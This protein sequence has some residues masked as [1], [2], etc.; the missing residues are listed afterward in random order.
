MVQNQVKKFHGL[1]LFIGGA[2]SQEL[3]QHVEAMQGRG[4]GADTVAPQCSLP[5]NLVGFIVIGAAAHQLDLSQSRLG[6][7][8]AQVVVYGVVER[9]R[10]LRL[11]PRPVQISHVEEEKGQA[12]GHVGLV[13]RTILDAPGVQVLFPQVVGFLKIASTPEVFGIVPL[14]KIT[15][16]TALLVAAGSLV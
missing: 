9:N 5:Q 7:G 6:G 15:T 8:A 16:T 13:R 4:F 1:A 14:G 2:R 11:C 10:R 12:F 3:A